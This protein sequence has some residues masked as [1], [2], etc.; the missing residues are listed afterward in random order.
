MIGLSETS[1]TG[2]AHPR[3]SAFA[4]SPLRCRPVPLQEEPDHF[5]RGVRSALVGKRASRTPARPGMPKMIN[6]PL[7]EERSMLRA[8]C[9][10]RVSG[11]SRRLR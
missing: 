11:T 2:R 1:F 9:G 10:A 8:E 5:R 7:L 6:R 3:G 4:K